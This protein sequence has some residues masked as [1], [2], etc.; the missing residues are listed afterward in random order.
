MYGRGMYEADASYEADAAYDE[1]A[2]GDISTA[3]LLG[4]IYG[5]SQEPRYVKIKQHRTGQWKVYQLLGGLY[6]ATDAAVNFY[7][8]ASSYLKEQ[9]YTRYENEICAFYNKTTKHK[10]KRFTCTRTLTKH[11]RATISYG[12]NRHVHIFSLVDND[13]V[14]VHFTIVHLNALPLFGLLL[15]LLG[16]R[17]D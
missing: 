15:L 16:Y 17:S 13:V 4:N 2:I 10:N 8:T 7:D 11:T 6:G 14:V 12:S 9:G 3:F 1:I 5:D